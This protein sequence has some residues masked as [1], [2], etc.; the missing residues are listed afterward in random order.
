M[1]NTPKRNLK[2]T[3]QLTPLDKPDMSPY[4][5][6]LTTKDSLIKILEDKFLKLQK[7]RGSHP[8]KHPYAMVCFTESPPFALD[9]FRYRWND[10]KDREDLT[11]GIGFS[12]EKMAKK[13]VFPTAYLDR[14]LIDFIQWLQKKLNN[15][16]EKYEKENKKIRKYI[17]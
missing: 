11:Y 8:D 2:P 1:P 3:F 14:E 17:H 9:F 10:N 6:H 12:K 4:L 5:F 13:G 15:N 7:P 16:S